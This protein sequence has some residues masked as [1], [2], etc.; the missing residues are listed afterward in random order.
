MTPAEFTASLDALGWS[1]RH[2]ARLLECDTNMPT[3]WARGTVQVPPSIA[4]WLEQL[5]WHHECYGV[6]DDWRIR[7][8]HSEGLEQ[9]DDER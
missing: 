5:V 7:N 8:S 1:Q 2:L 4:E 6:P 3:R 9:S